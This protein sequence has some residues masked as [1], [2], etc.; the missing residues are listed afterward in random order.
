M[1]AKKNLVK[2]IVFSGLAVIISY[3][4]N[5]FLTPYITDKLGTEAY[6]F[7]TLARTIVSYVSIF[8]VAF[9]SFMVRY[10]ALEYHKKNIE[11]SVAYFSSSIAVSLFINVIILLIT[12]IIS[13]F[14]TSIFNIPNDLIFD[15]KILFILVFLEFGISTLVVP[16]SSS[17]YIK[18]KLNI[19]HI[20]KIVS[21]IIEAAVLLILYSL[22]RTHI[23]YVGLSLLMASLSVLIG[24]I[25]ISRILTPELHFSKEKVSIKDIYQLA[26]N[27]LWQ[28]V[29]SLGVVLNTGLDLWVSNIMLSSLQMGQISISKTIGNMFNVLYANISQAFQPR[30]LKT[31]SLPEKKEFIKELKF[32]MKACGGIT[33]CAFAGFT[34]L[35]KLYFKLWLPNQDHVLLYNLTLITVLS[36][37]TD[38][39]IYPA[40]YVNTL[41]TKKKI[42]C[43]VT[44]GTGVL[45][46]IGMFLLLKFTNM[47]I[48]SIVVTTTVLM[49]I[50]NGI[51]NPIYCAIS[52]KLPWYSLFPLILKHIFVSSALVSIFGL[53]S[54]I[55]NP[56][57]WISLIA[58]AII[59]VII[60]LP[61]YSIVMINKSE[62]NK[63]IKKLKTRK[64]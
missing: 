11:K 17:Y 40:Y 62:R 28:S 8:S 37:L 19:Y 20:F 44:I 32:A 29:N 45:N 2:T 9:T 24:T 30:M 61:L 18:D 39:I 26:K 36:S 7:V 53:I 23:W 58:V 63:I 13:F 1:K 43:L 46:V 31:Y 38:G 50:T 35:G 64:K 34:V 16:F 51:F 12:I 52:L 59:L 14:I 33:A 10:I 21:Y 4:I 41:T 48:Y 55:L 42:P 27:G 47:G 25:F 49:I 22:M 56:K 3:L 5:F 60:G 54:I 57:S 15:V 6:G